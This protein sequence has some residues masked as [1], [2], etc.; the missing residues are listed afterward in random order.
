MLI[1]VVDKITPRIKYT[2]DFIFKLRGL[3]YKFE[4]NEP[5]SMELSNVIFYSSVKRK[6]KWIQQAKIIT[7]STIYSQEI[8]ISQFGS[9]ECYSFD[10]VTDPISSI[11]YHL[12]RYE[13]YTSIKKDQ[14]GRFQFSLSK[15]SDNWIEKV[16][17]DRWA[18]EV[19]SFCGLNLNR[20]EG[21]PLI[22]P[23][24][25]IDN[26]YAYKLKS[27]KRKILSTLKDIVKVDGSRLKER[28]TVNSGSRDPYDTYS[29]IREIY[30]RFP[31]TRMFWLVG[32][33]GRYDRNI[34]IKNEKHR[35]LIRKMKAKGLNIGLHPSYASFND[36]DKLL[37]EKSRLAIV[38]SEKM[39]SSRQHYLRFELPRTY[40]ILQEAGFEHEYSMGFAERA[41]FRCGTARSHLWFDLEKN[42]E[43]K[44]T[45]HPFAY[46]DGTL[47]EYMQLTISQ[48]KEL[49]RK[50]YNEVS[51]FGGEFVFIWHNE[52][53]GDY[54]IWKGW[55]EVLDHSLNLE[56]E[57]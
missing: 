23:T 55:R 29:E 11:F 41:G 14:H 8:G 24:F 34:S 48:S 27:G 17:C 6:G 28:R 38:V 47:N 39:R 5:K 12:T 50:L 46:M 37:Q 26:T 10:D 3:S 49:I 53:I 52:T 2:L 45:V 30:G 4:L 18:E 42:Q 54:G 57:S 40:Q 36:L 21:K 1:I 7:E 16:M 13:E 15:L 33:K 20:T 32:S 43:S 35:R 51:R 22:V 31:S 19:I 56:D 9:E 25:D 44:L